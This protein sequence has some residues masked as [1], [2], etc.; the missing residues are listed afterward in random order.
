ME[1]TEGYAARRDDDDGADEVPETE[2]EFAHA[3][4]DYV[5]GEW[6]QF[7]YEKSVGGPDSDDTELVEVPFARHVWPESVYEHVDEDE[8][9]VRFVYRTPSGEVRRATISADAFGSQSTARTRAGELMN[10]GVQVTVDRGKEFAYA[11]G[12]WME[13][14]GGDAPTVQITDTPGWHEGGDVYVNGV[15]VFGAQDWYAREEA[16]AIERRSGRAGAFEAWCQKMDRLL[17]TPGLRCSLGVALAGPLVEPLHPH[18]FIVHMYGESSSG[19]STGGEVGASVYGTMEAAFNSWYGT[20]TSKENLAEIA[21]GACLVLDELGQFPHSDRKLAEVIYN[22]CSDQGKTRSTQSG[23][24][25]Q[26]RSW[27]ITCLSTGEISMKD[28]VG[29]YRKGGQDVRMIDVPIEIGEMT[30]SREHSNEV[31]RAVGSISGNAHAGHAGDMWTLYLACEADFWEMRRA[32]QDEHERLIE[33][34]GDDTAETDRILQSVALVS[35]AMQEAH[36]LDGDHHPPLCPWPPKESREA[37]NWLAERAINDRD[38]RTPHERAL[39]LWV[40]KV[41]TEQ[42]HFPTGQTVR[43][44]ETSRVIWGVREATEEVWVSESTVKA[45]GLPREA[46]VGVRAWLNWLVDNGLAKDV[47]RKRIGGMQPRWKAID[48]A[49]VS[50]WQDR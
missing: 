45:S 42:F 9:G 6:C 5:F 44:S 3:G 23:D 38:A 28:R 14:C 35:V 47:G 10:A 39:T 49:A 12:R 4:R 27:K 13:A 43:E 48:M 24:L 46:G 20:S 36:K 40:E 34:Y 26:Q 18:S 37:A 30:E 8:H 21:D 19:K 11:L 33:A 31:K 1:L 32:K 29:H 16:R 2:I 15:Q 17:T 50:K 7:S 22:I 41:E 25:Q